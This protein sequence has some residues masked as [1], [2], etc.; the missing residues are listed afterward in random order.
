MGDND[1]QLNNFMYYFL[2]QVNDK[3]SHKRVKNT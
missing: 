3:K 1:E 2:F